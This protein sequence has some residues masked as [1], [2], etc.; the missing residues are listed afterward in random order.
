MPR[1]RGTYKPDHPKPY[2]ISRSQIQA[3]MNC[4]ACFL[5]E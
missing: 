1:H 3:F 4:P 2:E 5:D